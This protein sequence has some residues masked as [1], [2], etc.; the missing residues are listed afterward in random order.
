MGEVSKQDGVSEVN[1][2]EDF[3]SNGVYIRYYLGLEALC[4][5]GSTNNFCRQTISLFF[6]YVTLGF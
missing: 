4:H 6:S 3:P 2:G 5:Q 1:I